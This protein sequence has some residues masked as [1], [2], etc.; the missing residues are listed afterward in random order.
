VET[1]AETT[2]D[3][4]EAK[5]RTPAPNLEGQPEEFKGISLKNSQQGCAPVAVSLDEKFSQNT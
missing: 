2:E 3:A 5:P 1:P 4:T